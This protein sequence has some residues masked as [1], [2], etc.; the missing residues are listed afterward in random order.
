MIIGIDLGEV[1][2]EGPLV[3]VTMTILSVIHFGIMKTFH[4]K[5]LVVW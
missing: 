5:T 3:I 1:G 4:N 2:I